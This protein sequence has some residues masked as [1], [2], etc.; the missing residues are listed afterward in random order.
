MIRL[1]DLCA[2]RLDLNIEYDRGQL[3]GSVTL[4]LGDP[5]SD[6]EL[7]AL[8]NHVLGARGFTT[9]KHRDGF[10]SVVKEQSAPKLGR[11][12]DLSTGE[13]LPGFVTVAK[14]VEHVPVQQA[15]DAL[16]VVVT[17]GSAQVAPL[18][19]SN[20]M[21]ISDLRPRV[22]RALEV[23]AQIDQPQRDT[24]L[25][26]HPAQH[27]SASSLAQA[28]NEILQAREGVT[29]RPPRGRVVALPD[30][31]GVAIVAPPAEI[32][33][34]R[35][36]LTRLED[37]EALRTETYTPIHFSLSEVSSLIERAL[38]I[39]EDPRARRGPF[40]LVT[41]ELTGSLLVTAT[42]AQHDQI[43]S[44][45]KRL[46]EVPPAARRQ[47]RTYAIKNRSVAEVVSL[48]QGL[49]A[50]RVLA[51]EEGDT[52]PLDSTP[53]QSRRDVPA[54]PSADSVPPP[55]PGTDARSPSTSPENPSRLAELD[56]PVTLAAD[57]ATNT[58]IAIGE[59]RLL[60]QLT[61]LVDNLDVRQPQVLLEVIAVSLNEA[62]SLDLGVELQ[63]LEESGQTQISLSSV[64]SLFGGAPTSLA[65]VA[66]DGFTGL[67]LHP[68]DFSVL[69]RALRAV[70]DGRSVNRPKVL[71]NNN[72]R[73]TFD[74]VLQQ[75]FLSTNAS[76]TVATT[77]FGGTQDAGTSVAVKPTIAEGDHL[78]LEVQIS[79]SEFLGEQVSAAL[80]PPRQQNT[81]ASV[82]TIPDGHTVILGGIEVETDGD[83]A[84]G[85]PWLSQ[86]PLLGWLF[87]T[88]S[89]ST[90]R[91]RFFVFLR[92]NVMRHGRFEDLKYRSAVDLDQTRFP[93]HWPELK[94]RV[95][96]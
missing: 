7:W 18:L 90:S 89:T 64:F 58:L 8:T 41:D 54:G 12:D 5:L 19:P 32:G 95:M 30:A 2:E 84:A 42:P 55:T 51:G 93:D 25:E 78:V 57:E 63:K 31:T 27:L 23:L 79:L 61:Q 9:V 45:L 60:E 34:F 96:R 85:V 53:Q 62:D 59:P 29:G 74:S 40:R 75:P 15:V 65:D 52:N 20:V 43:E 86:I 91:T 56:G 88:R 92:A 26:V 72:E 50:A 80:P 28:A 14:R 37:R 94:P 38:G 16:K 21:L 22:E 3:T 71:V 82:V 36:V 87:E 70:N 77:S 76:D 81:L 47:V 73:A 17:G 69:L 4:R 68:G 10:F 1:V 35:D 11:L 13:L 44:I 83:S 33:L 48:L 39:D 49:I 6:G 67:V 24:T 66:G 46:G